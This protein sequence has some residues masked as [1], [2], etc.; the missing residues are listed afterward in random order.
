MARPLSQVA[1]GGARRAGAVRVAGGLGLA[2][3]A[4]LVVLLVMA[5]LVAPPD[6]L[7]GQSQRLMYVHVPAAWTAFAAFGVVAGCSVASLLGGADRAWAVGGAAAELGVAMTGLTLVVGSLWGRAA[8][9][10]WWTWDPRVL[11]TAVLFLVYVAYLAARSLADDARWGRR[12]V[13]VLGLV[14]VVLVPVV[15]FSVLWWRT[16]HQPPTLLAPS[17]HPPIAPV[18]LVTLLI[19]VLTFSLAGCWY[20]VRRTVTLLADD[21]PGAASEVAESR[22]L[23][24]ARRDRSRS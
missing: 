3:L 17:A 10:V 11:S 2:A 8:W 15:H 19:G 13:A 9:G 4:W 12:P 14:G 21:E 16:L 18:M 20:V 6:A 1:H 23:P 22:T 7:Q 5:L 24:R